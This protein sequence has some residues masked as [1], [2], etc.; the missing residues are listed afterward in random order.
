MS[1]NFQ[2]ALKIIRKT[3]KEEVDKGAAFAKLCKIFFENDDIQKQQF[4]K[5]WFYNDWAKENPSFSKTD[6]GIDLVAKIVSE[7]GFCAIQCKCY[8]SDHTISKEDIDSF[9]SASSNKIFSRLI[10]IDTS[11]CDL[12]SNTKKVIENLDKAYQRIQTEEFEKSRI[13]WLSYLNKNQLVLKNKKELKD[14]QIQAVD[15]AKTHF[16]NNDR[17]KLIMACG[18]GKTLT[19]LKIAEKIAGKGKTI[20]YM[21][22]SLALM[23]QSIREWACESAISFNAFSACSDTRVGKKKS[24]DD[25]IEISLSD[26]AFPATTD[27]ELLATKIKEVTKLNNDMTVIFSTYQS[28]DVI[29][30]AQ[31][32]Y[33]L[34]EFDLIICDE[35]HRTTGA[36]LIDDD[37]DE[38]K[39]IRIHDNDY[40]KGKKRLYM[41]ATPKIYG[42]KAK[43]K[44]EEGGLVTISMDDEKLYGNMFFFKGFNWAVDNNLLT[45]YK[46]VV[47]KV[48]ESAIS[49]NLQ[50]SFAQGSELKLNDASKIIGCYKALA[51]IGIGENEFKNEKKIKP[52]KSALAFSQNIEIS[53][54][55]AKEFNRVIEDYTANEKVDDKNKINLEVDVNHIDGTFNA[56]Q[57]NEKLNWLKEDTGK[58]ICR[59]LTN[60]KCLS[61]GVDVPTLDAIIFLHPRK[62]QID[63]IQSVGR[64]MRKSEDKEIGYVILP[65]TIAPGVT[66]EKAL[67]DSDRYSVVWQVLNALRSHDERLDSTINR[68]KLGEDVSD[69]IE[70]I[71]INEADLEAS[72]AVVDDLKS[73]NKN[74]TKKKDV[75]IGINKDISNIIVDQNNQLPLEYD[76]SQAIKAKIVEKCGTRDYW[77]TWANDI[78]KIAKA[79][80]IRINSIVLK[81]K[82][83]ERKIFLS[84][85]DE[86]RD[87]LNQ[88]ITEQDAIEMLAQHIIT[89]P[90]FDTLFQ[91]SP[92]T[93]ENI[94]SKSIEKVVNKIYEKGIETESNSLLQFYE[95]VKRRS[96]DIV[97]SAGRNS[98][99]NELY[100]RF[101]KNAFPLTTSKLGIVYTPVEIVDFILHSVDDILQSEFK[102][103][104]SDKNV[105]I[106]DPFTGTGTFIA[107][108]L[109]NE[110]IK[111]E[112]LKYKYENE[113]HANEIV[114]LAYYIAGINI[115][116]I[117]QDIVKEN[118]YNPFNGIVLTDTFQ[119][120]EQERDMVANLLPDNSDKRKKQKKRKITVI[121]GNPPYSSGQR[122]SNDNAQ[123]VKYPN[124][125]NKIKKT[126][127]EY[128]KATLK[129]SLYDSYIRAIRWASD[130]IIDDGVIAYVTP[131]GW[132]DGLANDGMRKTLAEEFSKIFVL[133]LR[134]N[135]RTQGEQRR[136]ERGNIFGEGSKSPIAITI[137]V[138]NKYYKKKAEIFYFDI[139]DYLS[140]KDK[141]N[142]IRFYKSINQIQKE[143]K[144]SKIIPDNNND[145]I[146]KGSLEY[147]KFVSLKNNSENYIFE[148]LGPG[149]STSRD[150][151]VYNSSAIKLKNNISLMIKNYNNLLKENKTKEQAFDI[152][153]SKVNWSR[154]L[155]NN[156]INKKKLTQD[157]EIIV[158]DYRPFFKQFLYFDRDLIEMRGISHLF[159]KSSTDRVITVSGVGAKPEFSALMLNH[160]GCM[161]MLEK[162][163]CLPLKIY[164]E[165]ISEQTDSLFANIKQSNLNNYQEGISNNILKLFK[166]KYSASNSVKINKENI[167]YYIYGVLHSKEYKEKFQND[168][169]KELPRIPIVKD[170]QD[171]LSFE[172]AGRIL[173]E[174]HVNYDSVEP[175]NLVLKENEQIKKNNPK[176]FYKVVKMKFDTKN[177][178]PDKTSVIYNQYI[179]LEKIPL[180]AYEYI[181]NKKS[182]LEWV[183]ERQCIKIDNE[184][185][186]S[187]DA[188]DFA[189]EFYKDPSYPLK[190]F[191]K[192][193]NV[194]LKT[195]SIVKNLPKLKTN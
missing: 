59:I 104:L 98:L 179:K 140:R 152:D 165:E 181:V 8:E 137:L 133:N 142:I 42:T 1:N 85:L 145:W 105:H 146:N 186:L 111:K 4:S 163:Q 128:S 65:I 14:H 92:F 134:G 113:I 62:S 18:T 33:K 115:E 25:S 162:T 112:D 177:S 156:F 194:S 63:V 183:M 77:E 188:N 95:S 12:G 99:I 110:L 124:L 127:A 193:I 138:K 28:I 53:K 80:I 93:R 100:E 20:L 158:S 11:L 91:S 129:N 64:V 160:L 130:R 76:F 176:M 141:L 81:S 136:K 101:F 57:R 122:R 192:I 68:I 170:P 171:F 120:Y 108:L 178:Q 125:D 43:K 180:E 15:A 119:M 47:L 22:P 24:Q 75:E 114:L 154:G 23:S 135:A 143:K 66:A 190:L 74:E 45:D 144:F 185:G 148:K 151:W 109:Q 175:Y 121:V 13:D 168:L 69:K 166:E 169:I 2:E 147:K 153:P 10:L 167:F 107:R 67:N 159:L 116:S 164:Y 50:N 21:V 73:K 61:E 39:F 195:M 19:S 83:A 149:I 106:L 174:L 16:K 132:V 30:K 88:D 187:N 118:Q 58:N 89:K 90:V 71:D 5:V 9:I 31:S 52:I 182:A 97:T 123:N 191:L 35:A 56:Q 6:I 79:H 48:D 7:P 38:S 87:D 46:V 102:K 54:L 27:P 126:Y 49:Q 86:I 161:D 36:T 184:S 70:I 32:K 117:Y 51:K 139:G 155:K 29:S 131:L 150:F 84:F 34:K 103:S 44:A 96:K 72:T 41:T 55:F 189:I 94:V 157:G 26:L 3:A 60:V 172:K 173:S 17:G 37:E 78:S 82:S 40:V